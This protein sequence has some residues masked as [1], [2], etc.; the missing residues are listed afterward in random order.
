MS[1]TTFF[2]FE[3]DAALETQEL[4][5][6]ASASMFSYWVMMSVSKRDNVHDLAAVLSRALLPMAALIAGSL[7]RDSWSL[8][9]S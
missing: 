6:V 8:T 9:S 1:S 4:L 2:A 7:A 3:S 5:R